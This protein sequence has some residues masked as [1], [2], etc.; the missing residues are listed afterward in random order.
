MSEKLSHDQAVGA[1]C[2]CASTVTVLSYQ[3]AIEGYFA[4][5]GISIPGNSLPRENTS[6]AEGYEQA[7]RDAS[8]WL[9]GPNVPDHSDEGGCPFDKAAAAILKLLE[10]KDRP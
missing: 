7:I 2:D 9:R 10:N 4:L 6:F 5:R 3:E 8:K 1:L